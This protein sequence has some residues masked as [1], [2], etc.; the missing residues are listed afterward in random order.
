MLTLTL[1]LDLN[2]LNLTELATLYYATHHQT[3]DPQ[4]TEILQAMRRNAS[5]EEI[6]NEVERI[7]CAIGA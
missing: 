5:W 2:R 6:I 1:D 3:S 4:R 7:E